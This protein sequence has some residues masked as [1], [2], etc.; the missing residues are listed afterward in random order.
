MSQNEALCG[1]GLSHVLLLFLILRAVYIFK[2]FL[3]AHVYM[4]NTNQ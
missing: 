4:Y 3:C 2:V 1:N